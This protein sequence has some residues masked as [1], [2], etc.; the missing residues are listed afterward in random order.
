MNNWLKQEIDTRLQ[1]IEIC[2]TEHVPQV[3]VCVSM[4]NA[5]KY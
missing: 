1:E 3:S 2:L 4:Y 5:S